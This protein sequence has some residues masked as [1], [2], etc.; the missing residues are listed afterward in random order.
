MEA[1][2]IEL[3]L[4]LTQILNF[5]IVLFVLN[6]F[7]YKPI[8]RV[9]EERRQKIEEGLAWS[10]KA[11]LEEEKMNKRKQELLRE[12]KD[13]ARVILENAKK[14]AKRLKD[15]IVASGHT[16]VAALKVRQQQELVAQHEQMSREL[17]V[18]T[19]DIAAAMVKQILPEVLTSDDQHRVISSQLKKIAK[20]HEIK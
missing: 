8:L 20:A 19:V 13:E 14:D 7:L 3:P 17:S 18:Q 5:I 11:R 12:A 6:R 15:E 1:L 16:E 10:E 2:G 9:L 4:L